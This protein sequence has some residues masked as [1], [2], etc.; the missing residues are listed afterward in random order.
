MY[1]RKKPRNKQNKT[2]YQYQ[3]IKSVRTPD[4][5]RQR[6]LLNLGSNL[7][8]EDDKLLQLS[9]LIED[10]IKGKIKLFNAETELEKYAEHYANLLIEK[11]IKEEGQEIKEE[12]SERIAKVDINSTENKLFKTIGPEHAVLSEINRYGLL[13]KLRDMG[14]SKVQAERAI[15]LIVGRAVHPASERE[16]ARWLRNNSGLDQLLDTDF[17]EVSDNT[18]HRAADKLW[19][20]KDKIEEHLSIRSH[21]L[22]NLQDKIVLYDLTNTFFET[23]KEDSDLA[24]FGRSKERRNDCPLVSL[25]LVTDEHGFPKKSR[26]YKGNVSEYSTLK[27]IL[28]DLGY[29]NKELEIIHPTVVLDSGIASEENLALL[30]EEGFKYIVVSSKKSLINSLNWDK[31]WQEIDMKDDQTL[32]VKGSATEAE[33]Y[34][35]CL[36]ERKLV[37]EEAIYKRRMEEFEQ[38]I[39]DL[40]AGLS[41]KYKLKNYEKVLEKIGRLKEEYK[42]GG[43]FDIQVEKKPDSEKAQKVTIK[44]REDKQKDLFKKTGK[45]LLRTNR[46]DLSMES[47]SQI[48]RSLTQ[49]EKSFRCMKSDLGLRPIE[50]QND[51]RIK[52]HIFITVLAYY[53]IAGILYRIRG[54]DF[55][56]NSWESIR[57]LLAS[58]LRGITSFYTVDGYRIDLKNST[59]TT[60]DQRRIYK[61][62]KIQNQ[63]KLN[64]LIKT[65]L[66]T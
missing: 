53:I 55:L 58:H 21:Q 13:D 35:L 34:L 65:K 20:N 54:N 26:I 56:P 24:N 19:E 42:V 10:K 36:S 41:Q 63:P 31:K 37:K 12:D 1:I 25:A 59:V 33:K 7:D 22:Y 16:T 4:G 60:I 49:I 64:K 27:D 17:S 14:L 40:D 9:D 8:I 66:K 38:E 30:D 2:Y 28:Q 45:Y 44:R 43:L 6:V 3:L 39:K 5:P 48:H 15:G 47:I 51:E 52:A 23:S 57:S 18:L 46:T 11:R 61:T 29:L 50:H 32:Y 62:L